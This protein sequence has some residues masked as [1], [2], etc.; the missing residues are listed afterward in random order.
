VHVE[1]RKS[2]FPSLREEALEV[3]KEKGREAASDYIQQ[4]MLAVLSPRGAAK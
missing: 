2:Q 4:E 3:W 1:R